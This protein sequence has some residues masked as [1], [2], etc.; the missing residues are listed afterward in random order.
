MRKSICSGNDDALFR[1]PN[2]SEDGQG[3]VLGPPYPKISIITPSFN[4]AQFLEE[5]ISSVLNQNYPN[6]E[7]IIIDGGST[8]GRVEIIKKYEKYL[9]YWV[10]EKNEGQADALNKGFARATGDIIG[11]LNSDDC[12]L[13]GTFFKVRDALR[14]VDIDAVYADCIFSDANGT[15]LKD[16]RSLKPV[17]WLMLFCCYIH[18]TTFFFKKKII[19][20]GI[21]IDKT[22]HIT[23]DKEFFAHIL[24]SDFKL[25]YVHDNFAVFR[26]HGGNKSINTGRVRLTRM[27]EGLK[28]YNRYS[29]LK[30]P[31]NVFFLG[32]YW[33]AQ[34]SAQVYKFL[35]KKI[36][37]YFS[38][39]SKECDH[40][41]ELR[42]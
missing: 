16:V 14:S 7:F 30:V 31:Y 5:A 9:A 41:N 12:Y 23:M 2:A 18:S 3:V 24:Y 37:H 15:Y 42:G 32:V 13:D 34:E 36:D 10:S 19:D 28:I 6:L 35:K 11:W 26:W 20:A 21:N 33:L 39:C 4:Q 27:R 29:G 22:F 38:F 25:K 40:M 8:D 17:K 1:P